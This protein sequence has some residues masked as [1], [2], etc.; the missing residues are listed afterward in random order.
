MIKLSNL[1]KAYNSNLILNEL[2]ATFNSGLIYIYG[3]SGSGKS[4]LLN[5]MAT[6]DKQTM[7]DLEINGINISQLTNKELNEFRKEELGFIFQQNNLIESLNVYDNIA[8]PLRINNFEEDEI[9]KLVFKTLDIVKMQSFAQR[10]ISTLSGGEKQK[11]AIARALVKKPSVILA[12]EITSSL[13]LINKK[14]IIEIILKISKETL[15]IL[16]THDQTLIEN[17]PSKA[18][19]IENKKLIPINKFKEELSIKETSKTYNNKKNNFIF[20]IKSSFNYFKTNT[21]KLFTI[22]S[23]L[24][25][26]SSIFVFYLTLNSFSLNNDYKLFAKKY[27]LQYLNFMDELVITDKSNENV[28]DTLLSDKLEID[29]S[30]YGFPISRGSDISID[31]VLFIDENFKIELLTGN[32]PTNNNE[33]IITDYLN[34]TLFFDA[35]VGDKINVLNNELIISGILKTNYLNDINRPDESSVRLMEEKFPYLNVIYMYEES[36]LEL[37]SNINEYYEDFV[38]RNDNG[39]INT[40]TDVKITKNETLS[41]YDVLISE[42]IA[43]RLSGGSNN[44]Y[45]LTFVRH[46]QRRVFIKVVSTSRT[47]DIEFSDQV[48]NMLNNDRF[49]YIGLIDVN[50]FEGVL[51]YNILNKSIIKPI[52]IGKSVGII[53]DSLII[54]LVIGVILLLV[55]GFVMLFITFNDDKTVIGIKRSLGVSKFEIYIYYSTIFTLV[56]VISIII[57]TIIST[58]A[59]YTFESTF[60]EVYKHFYLSIKLSNYTFMFILNILFLNIISIP[61]LFK[62]LNTN[63]TQLINS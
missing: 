29:N 57:S 53:T 35:N 23:L 8:Y 51:S 50:N 19:K 42:E 44:S 38:I 43:G 32:L 31:N 41:E 56:G 16:S 47:H 30:I 25:I 62:Y 48:Y 45:E 18:Y 36:Y 26:L 58:L 1:S 34:K 10:D 9:K 2:N 21:A 13:D 40:I 17:Y 46:N 15:V 11:I 63:E 7:G 4:T 27:E 12:D 55:F 49:G 60:N 22:I 33:V 54:A 24:A 20:H 14:E 52:D 61:Y 59:L 37:H 28:F 6:F 3:K 5:I 39:I